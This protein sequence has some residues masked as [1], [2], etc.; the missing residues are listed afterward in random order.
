MTMPGR[1]YTA[2]SGYRYGFNGKEQDKETTGT[3]TYD[4]GFRIYSPALGRFLSV[5]PLTKSYP[6]YT[7][8]QFA[9]NKPTTKIDLDGLE[10]FDFREIEQDDGSVLIVITTGKSLLNREYQKVSTTTGN[11]FNFKYAQI[12]EVLSKAK[13]N[14][15]TAPGSKDVTGFTIDLPITKDMEVFPG[16]GQIGE[17]RTVTNPETNKNEA[18]LTNASSIVFR[19]KDPKKYEPKIFGEGKSGEGNQEFTFN[20]EMTSGNMQFEFGSAF[21]PDQY[22]ITD[23]DGNILKQTESV[24]GEGTLNID[25]KDLK[26]PII[27]VKVISSDETPENSKWFF[28]LRAKESTPP[29]NQDNKNEKKEKKSGDT[30]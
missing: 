10:E 30:E 18:W 11:M 14:E 1:K 8:Y 28:K 23:A 17:V 2:A 24:S 20:I 5:D 22:V 26:K 16:P 3:T 6:W 19:L 12:Q 4:Y 27:K 29:V 9:G 21:V 13:Y 25:F 15:V 7:P